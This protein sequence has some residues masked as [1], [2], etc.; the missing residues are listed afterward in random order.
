MTT[1]FRYAHFDA[2]LLFQQ[3]VPSLKKWDFTSQKDS[4]TETVRQRQLDS[5]TVRRCD[6][7]LTLLTYYDSLTPTAGLD[8]SL[9][10]S[11]Y[12]ELQ[13]RSVVHAFVC[14]QCP[15]AGSPL[16]QDLMH[17]GPI[18]AARGLASA[19]LTQVFLC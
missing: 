9:A 11:K 8:I 14:L 6:G 7:D 17:D 1:F 16:P 10:L 19:A 3:F 15:F 4:E 18:S 5:E 12:P 2:S 13:N